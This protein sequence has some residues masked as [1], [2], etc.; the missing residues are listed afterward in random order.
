[1]AAR[2]VGLLVCASLWSCLCAVGAEAAP[3]L[4]LSVRPLPIKAVAN[5]G[6]HLGAGATLEFHVSITGA[7]YGGYPAPLSRLALKLPAGMRWDTTGFPRC[8]EPEFPA[9][10]PGERP[11][12]ERFPIGP[13]A[14]GASVK[15]IVAFGRSMSPETLTA[16]PFYNPAGGVTLTLYGHEPTSLGFLIEGTVG[17]LAHGR[18]E[19]VFPFSLQETVPG[20]DYVSIT[21]FT[22]LVGSARA[23][24][25][26]HAF[27]LRMPAEC[28][29]GSL[30]YGLQAVF[31][32]PAP[33]SADATY[34]ARCPRS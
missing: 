20:A 30:T 34:H 11:C 29:N 16:T 17:R 9:I 5:T 14:N 33:S 12:R 10:G 3:Q 21:S 7:E 32:G 25:H 22:L 26:G 13:I 24:R 4:S 27:S 2:Y 31:S 1:M 28:P 6:D 23:V 8:R 18:T 19:L 15:T